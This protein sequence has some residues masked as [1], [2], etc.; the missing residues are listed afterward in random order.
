ML[1]RI[2]HEN[3]PETRANRA[4]WDDGIVLNVVKHDPVP[5]GLYFTPNEKVL[6]RIHAKRDFWLIIVHVRMYTDA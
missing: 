6:L 3:P 4:S 2:R 5:S 1:L